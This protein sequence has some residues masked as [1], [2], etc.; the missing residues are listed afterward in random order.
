MSVYFI[1]CESIPEPLVK[2]GKTTNIKQRVQS[3]STSTPFL[4]KLIAICEDIQENELHDKFNHLRYKN[5]WFKF[6][7]E[8]REFI[9]PYEVV[10]GKC[11]KKTK[12]KIETHGKPQKTKSIKQPKL[13]KKSINPWHFAITF[14]DCFLLRKYENIF[15][16]KRGITFQ[17]DNT[18]IRLESLR[19]IIEKIAHELFPDQSEK[20]NVEKIVNF[21]MGRIPIE[22]EKKVNGTYKQ[23]PKVNYHIPEMEKIL[24]EWVGV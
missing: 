23:N 14:I 3:I 15:I 6:T 21:A 5:E 7:E 19:G 18:C 8:I 13:E 10:I 20:D 12:A 24:A 17:R 22:L 11:I 9:K 16:S 4:V 2:I 1:L